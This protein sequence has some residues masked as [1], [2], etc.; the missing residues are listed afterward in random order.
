MPPEN[1][2]EIPVAESEKS[3]WVQV[4]TQN[5][6][7]SRAIMGRL[8]ESKIW[9]II[10]E[11]RRGDLTNHQIAESMKISIIWVKKLWARYR[12]AESTKITYSTRIGRS[13]MA[14]PDVEY[15]AVISTR[16]KCACGAIELLI[17]MGY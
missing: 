15:S 17:N 10:R 16:H 9:R 4:M 12:H 14:Y 3:Q 11:E 1:L 2:D 6:I 13:E 7:S 5:R 8:D